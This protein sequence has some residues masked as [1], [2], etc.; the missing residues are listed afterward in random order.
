MVGNIL[1]KACLCI[2]P[3]HLSLHVQHVWNADMPWQLLLSLELLGCLLQAK[4]C[5]MRLPAI[6]YNLMPRSPVTLMA[7]VRVPYVARARFLPHA[8]CL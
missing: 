4:H 1:L 8:F 3:G 5:L 2:T 7:R 6:A